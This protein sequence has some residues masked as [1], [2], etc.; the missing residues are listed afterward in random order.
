MPEVETP[1]EAN[2]MRGPRILR[3]VRVAV[4]L[5]ALLGF[6][7]PLAAQPVTPD[8]GRQLV[9]YAV[10]DPVLGA[11]SDETLYVF[12]QLQDVAG[13]PVA[14]P[15]PLVVTLSS[16]DP[17]VLRPYGSDGDQARV[18]GSGSTSYGY[19][20]FTSPA[21]GVATITATAPGFAPA[22][23]KVTTVSRGGPA[24]RLRLYAVPPRTADGDR[25]LVFVQ[26][27]DA[28]GRPANPA[29]NV[30]VDI[31]ASVPGKAPATTSLYFSNSYT[32]VQ[33]SGDPSGGASVAALAASAQDVAGDSVQLGAAEAAPAGAPAAPSIDERAFRLGVE[34]AGLARS[35]PAHAEALIAERYRQAL[36]LTTDETLG[37]RL[38]E[39]FRRGFSSQTAGVAPPAPGAA[40]QPAAQPPPARGPR[41]FDVT[42]A[43]GVAQG[44]PVG[45]GG[46]FT[47][48]TNPIYVWFRHEGL[49]AGT[50][51]TCVWYYLETTPV[52]RIADAD[53]TLDPPTD[54]GQFNMELP[55]GRPW[56]V[57][58][59]R[60]ELLLAGRPAA[61]ARFEIVA[62][63]A[64]AAPPAP[65]EPRLYRH[66][67]AGF[68]ILPPPGWTLDDHVSPADLQMKSAG[69]EG[70]MEITSGPTSTKLDAVSYAAGWESNAVGPDKLLHAKRAGRLLDVAGERAY[71]AVYEGDGVLAKVVFV[72]FADRFFVM[73]GVFRTEDF[74]SGE[75]VFD[76][77][78]ESF[79]PG[80]SGGSGQGAAVRGQATFPSQRDSVT[81]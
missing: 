15:G 4:G 79:K 18:G 9:L 58:N 24:T 21:P 50:R 48:D 1:H 12:V 74:A 56:P 54:W 70:L 29:R 33:V 57:G 38:T 5:L 66:P 28:Q 53:L 36:D 35:D 59:Y 25:R 23:M 75:P 67:R 7:R 62:N 37:P 81:V 76:R 65:A 55:A 39:A 41:L 71:E 6:A 64:A 61:E 8:A 46:T 2:G 44:R 77:V 68:Q 80:R 31:S 72:G 22:S 10:P 16:S 11:T 42:A 78:V 26:F 69:G 52:M 13:T 30:N 40:A 73:T 63:A 45:P 19:G 3:Q 20:R 27:L 51:V 49:P 32:T 17:A 60:V 14:A 47:S 34:A 43:R